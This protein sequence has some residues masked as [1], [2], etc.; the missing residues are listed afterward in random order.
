MAVEK[1]MVE[2]EEKK[3]TKEELTSKVNR[4]TIWCTKF[5]ISGVPLAN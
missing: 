4:D 5:I 1:R 3:C 2:L